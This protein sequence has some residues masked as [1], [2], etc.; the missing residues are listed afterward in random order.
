M[1]TQFLERHFAE[2]RLPVEFVDADPRRRNRWSPT[3]RR[4]VDEFFFVDVVT[5]R[6]REQR[7]RIFADD[8][9]T[10]QLLDKR[11]AT[12]HLLLQVRAEPAAR[13]VSDTYLLGHD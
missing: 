4:P 10:L 1:D 13:K 8:Q 5:R 6:Q 11:P 7:F 12:R 2:C 3:V 9:A